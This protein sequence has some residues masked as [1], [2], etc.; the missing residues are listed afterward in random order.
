MSNAFGWGYPAGAEHDPNAPYNQEEVP[1]KEFDVLA[2]QTLSK[3]NKVITDNYI[4]GASWVEY[5]H[6]EEGGH[7]IGC[8]EPDDTS[9]TNWENEY[10]ANDHYMPSQLIEIFKNFLENVLTTG[11]REWQESLAH[12]KHLF[13]ECCGW[14]EDETE[15]IEE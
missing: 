1:E 7:A 12:T 11:N 6:D 14:S 3:S 8:H 10:H 9:D 5:E 4:P 2:S 13:Q 15:V